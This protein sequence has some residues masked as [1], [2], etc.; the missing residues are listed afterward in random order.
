MLQYLLPNQRLSILSPKRREVI[1]EL[2]LNLE[3]MDTHG[4]RETSLDLT[5][6]DYS[7]QAEQKEH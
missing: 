1:S 7:T 5:A 3:V 4:E 2:L 6:Y